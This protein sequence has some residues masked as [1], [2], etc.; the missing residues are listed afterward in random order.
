[1]IAFSTTQCSDDE[2][3]ERNNNAQIKGS[4]KTNE[5]MINGNCQGKKTC[6]E[7]EERDPETNTCSPIENKPLPTV[8]I[9]TPDLN[10]LEDI[11][12]ISI[13]VTLSQASLDDI[14]VPFTVTKDTIPALTYH[15]ND[16]NTY[17]DLQDG[18]FTI[19]AGETTSSITF[20]V[21]NTSE[22]QADQKLTIELDTPTYATL[23]EDTQLIV[24]I[25]DT[26]TDDTATNTAADELTAQSILADNSALDNITSSLVLPSSGNYETKITWSLPSSVQSGGN[27]TRPSYS[28]GNK[29]L[30]ITATI[31][32]G[33]AQTSKDFTLTIIRNDPTD[34]EA[35]SL[36]SSDLTDSQVL[37][38]NSSWSNILTDLNFPSSG[39]WSTSISWSTNN[40]ASSSS[41]VITRPSYSNGDQTVTIT[42]TVTKGNSQSTK[43]FTATVIKNDPND[44]E[45]VSLAASDLTDSQVLNN[46]S[47]WSNILT[48]LNFPTSGSWNAS[49]NW[50][51]NNSAIASDGGIT[52]PAFDASN[53]SVEV[54][55]TI[56][57][58]SAETTKS[59]NATV[60]LSLPPLM[61]TEVYGGQASNDG[62][63]EIYNTTDVS[64]TLSNYQIRTCTNSYPC[65]ST[66]SFTISSPS[67]SDPNIAIGSKQYMLIHRRDDETAVETDIYLDSIVFS[68]FHDLAEITEI[69]SS[70]TI[71]YV[72][73]SNSDYTGSSHPDP[74]TE[75]F[76]FT[77]SVLMNNFNYETSIGRKFPLPTTDTNNADEWM[78]YDH[79]SP[80]GPNPTYL[81]IASGTDS[82]G[83]GLSD[84]D[85]DNVYN[86]DKTR[87]DTDGDG[88][89]DGQEVLDEGIAGINI[90][91]LGAD[92][93]KRDIFLEIDYMANPAGVTNSDT[94]TT[95]NTN[96]FILR[97]AALD[98]IKNVFDNYNPA[99][100]TNTYSIQIHFDVGDLFDQ[101]DGIDP[102]DYDLG[103]GNEIPF[104]NCISLGPKDNCASDHYA[105]KQQNHDL[106]RRF[107][108]HYFIRGWSQNT[109]G[110]T[111]SSGLA[112]LGGNDGI[113]TVNSDLSNENYC[114]NVQASTIFHEL[115]HNMNLQHGGNESLNYKPNYV[116]T[117]NYLYQLNGLDTDNDGDI[118]YYAN[119]YTKQNGPNLSD[120]D[121]SPFS[122][123][124]VI[125]FSYG[126]NSTLDESSLNEANGWAGTGIDFNNSDSI[127]GTVSSNINPLDQSSGS[128][129]T[130]T[131]DSMADVDDW[132]IL[133]VPFQKYFTSTTTGR[134]EEKDDHQKLSEICISVP[135]DSK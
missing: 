13:S 111:G 68:Y 40:S 47:S 110:S 67:P 38:N 96:C 116:S 2:K 25:E 129:N 7:N 81:P 107:I 57:R 127:S 22:Y 39:S 50:S 70:K 115:G 72:R 82:D 35:V 69:S 27:V 134:F 92:P 49:I 23:G 15:S 97:K 20:N 74:T 62:W 99:G 128:S 46:N 91:A 102:N 53:V 18:S 108:F 56:T 1:M 79:A 87:S 119:E 58:G 64:I 131:N 44:S 36:A 45:A 9:S 37:N 133:D 61:I 42:A 21:Y 66:Q 48:D 135:P 126:T 33:D 77:G 8:N 43:E 121:I 4:C 17:Y 123:D 65:Q 118:F 3:I 34:Q 112:E 104:Y 125:N 24:V 122:S 120:L 106:N 6:T 75:S 60:I 117:M 109:D 95:T 54:T 89:S 5:V 90:K 80:G 73:W 28:D 88:F 130:T 14:S 93:L 86:T 98:K 114:T 11:E 32:K 100:D 63:V 84:D 52:R 76:T 51:T 16:N 94:D 12:T 41:G 55:A 71:D 83:D 19:S 132:N 85:E 101:S 105:L 124:F 103:G 31:T 10:I 29:T 59:F 30:T 113:I 78:F 26:I